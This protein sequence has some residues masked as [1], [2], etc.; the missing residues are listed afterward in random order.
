[1]HGENG[2]M[3]LASW[4]HHKEMMNHE[5]TDEVVQADEMSRQV[6]S[7]DEKHIAKRDQ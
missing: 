7:R 2:E 3:R 6:D 4:H 5:Q 1:M